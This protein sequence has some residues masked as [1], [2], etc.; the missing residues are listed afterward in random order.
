MCVNEGEQTDI[1]LLQIIIRT[2]SRRGKDA[3]ISFSIAEKK[4]LTQ[5]PGL[6]KKK[7][8]CFVLE[9]KRQNILS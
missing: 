7:R 6:W 3:G 4:Q 8:I 1:Y 9:R 5:I 2:L